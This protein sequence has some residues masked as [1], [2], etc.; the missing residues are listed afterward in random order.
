M[1][2]C[3]ELVVQ[4]KH[5]AEG[6]SIS[7]YGPANNMYI[8]SYGKLVLQITNGFV[9]VTLSLN[10]LARRLLRN[11]K[12]VTQ[13]LDKERCVKEQNFFDLL[14]VSCIYFAS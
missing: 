10:R 12:R 4:S 3:W 8:F 14:Y 7:L 13:I 6:H 5:K 11:G 1:E 2:D 9:Y